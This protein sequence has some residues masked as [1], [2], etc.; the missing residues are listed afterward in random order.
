MMMMM[1]MMMMMIRM[2][3]MMMMLEMKTPT[4]DKCFILLSLNVTMKVEEDDINV[5]LQTL[6]VFRDKKQ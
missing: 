6:S 1:M 4:T 2:T 3:M 5:P